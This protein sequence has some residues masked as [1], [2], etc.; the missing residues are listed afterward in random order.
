[1]G[2]DQRVSYG[3]VRVATER[4]RAVATSLSIC[5]LAFV[6]LVLGAAM[7]AAL[8]LGWVVFGA[9]AGYS[10]SGSV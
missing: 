7:P 2:R 8:A 4:D 6:L 1:M 5:G 10:I 9:S 3:M